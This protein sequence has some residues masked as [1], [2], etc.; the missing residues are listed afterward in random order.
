MRIGDYDRLVSVWKK[1]V[2]QDPDYG[3][4]IVDWVPLVPTNDSPPAAVRFWAN[5]Q[6]VLPSR[7]E[8]TKMN[9]ATAVDQ[10]RIRIYPWRD[11]VDSS[12]RITLHGRGGE[13]DQLFEIVAGP[14][15]LGNREAVEVVCVKYT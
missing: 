7:S 1:T 3:T 6:D 2:T 4:E 8:A 11:D 14:A 9:L 5:A 12:M 13:A 10:C 15:T